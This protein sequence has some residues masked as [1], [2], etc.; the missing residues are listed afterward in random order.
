MFF[1]EHYVGVDFLPKKKN[2]GQLENL[3]LASSSR[4]GEIGGG[5]LS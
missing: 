2:P 5:G 3:T 1:S 4:P